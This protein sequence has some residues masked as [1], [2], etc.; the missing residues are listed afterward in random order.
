MFLQDSTVP[1]LCRTCNGNH[2]NGNYPVSPCGYH[3]HPCWWHHSPAIEN[4]VVRHPY[5]QYF[6]FQTYCQSK[7][8]LL[9][10]AECNCLVAPKLCRWV[11]G[12][13]VPWK[14]EGIGG[15]IDWLHHAAAAVETMRVSGGATS[16]TCARCRDPRRQA[17]IVLILVSLQLIECCL[18]LLT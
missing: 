15:S 9:F 18:L 4:I 16:Q 13:I 6:T 8:P 7:A 5:S 10:W 1:Q 14:V 17:L 12:A 11:A 2:T 3:Q